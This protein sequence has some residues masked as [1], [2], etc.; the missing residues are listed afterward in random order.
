MSLY[1]RTNARIPLALDVQLKFKDVQLGQAFV[2][3]INP[4]GAFI[5]L[6]KP[7]LVTDDFI[8]IYFTNTDESQKCVVQKGVVIHANKEGVGVLF[9]SDNEEFRAMLDQEVTNEVSTHSG[10]FGIGT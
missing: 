6:P 3:N 10:A 2:R 9:A 8:K 1:H 4:F 5:E 7:Q